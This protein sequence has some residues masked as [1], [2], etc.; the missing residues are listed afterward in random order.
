[1]DG[2]PLLVGN[3]QQYQ[4]RKIAANLPMQDGGP[5]LVPTEVWLVSLL[6]VRTLSFR[7]SLETS[8]YPRYE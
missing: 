6:R 1:M 5:S 2:L 3:A 4:V 7:H 8:A